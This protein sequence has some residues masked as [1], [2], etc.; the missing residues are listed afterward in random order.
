MFNVYSKGCIISAGAAIAFFLLS[1]FSWPIKIN[2]FPNKIE[3]LV[4]PKADNFLRYIL[5]QVLNWWVMHSFNRILLEE[6][7]YLERVLIN[8]FSF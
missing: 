6:E 3:S 1:C 5:Q 2:F 4:I 7:V 8:I